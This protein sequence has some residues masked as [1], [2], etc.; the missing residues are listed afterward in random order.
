M[1]E[2]QKLGLGIGHEDGSV[3]VLVLD[4]SMKPFGKIA[5]KPED[6]VK[7]ATL[8]LDHARLAT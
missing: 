3:T 8:L 1:P 4:E 2:L 6:A 7:I 5:Y